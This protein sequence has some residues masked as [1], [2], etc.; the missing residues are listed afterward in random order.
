M[1]IRRPFRNVALLASFLLTIFPLGSR[2]Q[3]QQPP[4]NKVLGRV[5]FVGHTKLEKTAGVWVDEQYVGYVDELKND[6]EVLLLPGKHHLSIRQTGY[7]DQDQD[8]SVSPGGATQVTVALQA[9][10]KAEFSPVNAQVKLSVTPD[11]A[12]VMVDG[13]FA[14]IVHDFGGVGR[15][16][17][18][19][20]G[21]HHVVIDL[22][23]YQP[24]ETDIDVQANQKV[25]I[26]T[27][28]VQGSVSDTAPALKK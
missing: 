13:K 24:F 25:T 18:V 12:A 5:D 15:S 27:D 10:P 7:L 1:K 4:P 21:K 22:V 20:P 26:K 17:L 2:A 3:N 23:G 14:G 6:K 19:A 8:I 16:M 11:R 9:N 28:L